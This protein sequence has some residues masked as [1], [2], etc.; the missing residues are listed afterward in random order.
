MREQDENPCASTK[1]RDP[2]LNDEYPVLNMIMEHVPVLLPCM[3][4]KH[5]IGSAPGG[6]IAV[7]GTEMSVDWDRGAKLTGPRDV[8]YL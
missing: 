2:N 3:Q 7:T 5:R 1:V 8:T 6:F 4:K